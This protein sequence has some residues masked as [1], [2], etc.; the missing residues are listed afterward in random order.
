M[1][2]MMRMMMMML[3]RME[4]CT[5]KQIPTE[6]RDLAL[7][8]YPSLLALFVSCNSCLLTA[9]QFQATLF[10]DIVTSV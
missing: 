6:F 7:E 3:G 4:F 5:Q 9:Q 8:L 10:N 2:M 1:M